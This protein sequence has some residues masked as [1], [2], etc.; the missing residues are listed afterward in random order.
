[1]FSVQ[2]SVD[3]HW[4]PSTEALILKLRLKSW[5]FYKCKWKFLP[6]LRIIKLWFFPCIFIPLK[7]CALCEQQI[8][9]SLWFFLFDS[10]NEIFCV[11]HV[12]DKG[13]LILFL[14][15]VNNEQCMWL[16]LHNFA[17]NKRFM[18][19]VHWVIC[20]I[21]LF[22]EIFSV[23]FMSNEYFLSCMQS[24][25]NKWFVHFVS[26]MCDLCI[27]GKICIIYVQF[28]EQFKH[29]MSCVHCVS[30]EC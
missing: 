12:I 20:A 18:N 6:V 7:F 3:K 8:K 4:G 28:Y 19:C 14:D 30:N 1:M 24:M 17:S 27:L 23:F 9:C 5:D 29:S 26:N 25:N 13:C 10:F 15:C 2:Q 16:F 21:C 22:C 11:H